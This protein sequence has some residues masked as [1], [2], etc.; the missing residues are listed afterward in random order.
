MRAVLRGLPLLCATAAV[1][2]A[3]CRG[4]ERA[5]STRGV[6]AMQAPTDDTTAEV[7]VA[8][9]RP[10]GP[11]PG[12]SGCGWLL[13][14]LNEHGDDVPVGGIDLGVAAL[15]EAD[16]ASVLNAP[17]EAVVLEGTLEGDAFVVRRAYRALPIEATPAQ[18]VYIQVVQQ[19]A[20][21]CP[22]GVCEPS[23]AVELNVALDV[24][25]PALDLS[26]AEVP[27]LDHAWLS[28]RVFER[29]AVLS[30]TFTGVPG[31]RGI[32]RFVASEVFVPLPDRIA[33]CPTPAARRCREGTIEAYTR[34]ADRCLLDAGCLTPSRCTARPPDCAPGYVARTWRSPPGACPEYACDPAFLPE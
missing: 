10:A 30:G 13:R 7:W 5:S 29:G 28:S 14:P 18:E 26:S 3:A 15:D 25:L 21:R 24:P 31:G 27:G 19:P 20:T 12:P 34:D 33:P 1:S 6:T 2:L 17:N 4:G 11:C 16:R 23:H 9:L 8:L 22:S 32:A